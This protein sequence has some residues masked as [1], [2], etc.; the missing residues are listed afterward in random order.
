LEEFQVFLRE[1]A[2]GK[3][4]LNIINNKTFRTRVVERPL[5]SY[6]YYLKIFKSIE[7]LNEFGIVLP[8]KIDSK[9]EYYHLF[10]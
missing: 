1:T 6:E 5:F 3:E 10:F 2:F 7:T 8:K 9:K 4:F